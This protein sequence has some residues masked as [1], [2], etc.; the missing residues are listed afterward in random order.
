MSAVAKKH[1][2]RRVGGSTGVDDKKAL[3]RLSLVY[4]LETRRR[5]ERLQE[6]TGAG[7][8]TETIADA[9]RVFEW[10]VAQRAAGREI[11]VREPSGEVRQ[12]EFVL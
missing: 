11:L 1:T 5:L 9:I 8:I 6:Q 7:T 10:F 2:P 12:V 4:P 3:T